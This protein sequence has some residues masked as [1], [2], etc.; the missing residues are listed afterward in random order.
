MAALRA[1]CPWDRAQSHRSLV[2]YLVE[3]TLEVVE[4]IE[5]GDA[6]TEEVVYKPVLESKSVQRRRRQDLNA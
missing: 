4:A 2:H 1:G 5:D 6:D 3:E